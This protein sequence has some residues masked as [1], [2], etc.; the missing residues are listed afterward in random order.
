VKSVTFIPYS[1]YGQI[2]TLEY[3]IFPNQSIY[4]ITISDFPACTCDY[5]VNMCAATLSSKKAWL[6]CK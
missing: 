1:G 3:S 5:F 2:I 6:N 4:M